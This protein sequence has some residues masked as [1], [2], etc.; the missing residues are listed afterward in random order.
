MFPGVGVSS[1]T[2][3]CA[4]LP[5]RIQW[6][7]ICLSRPTG[8][9]GGVLLFFFLN[10]N[11]HQGKTVREHVQEFDFVGLFFIVAGILCLL[12]G[13]NESEKSCK[14]LAYLSCVLI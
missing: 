13:F 9:L 11:P 8:G 1:S 2:C 14:E 7:T 6:F 3:R 5:Q 10:L 12:F 4:T